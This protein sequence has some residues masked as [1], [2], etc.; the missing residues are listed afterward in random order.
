MGKICKRTIAFFLMLALT[1][2]DFERY[3]FSIEKNNV[4][5]AES[6]CLAAIT[7]AGVKNELKY[8]A[9]L[10]AGETGLVELNEKYFGDDI[11]DFKVTEWVSGNDSIATVS[12]GKITAIKEGKTVIKAKYEYCYYE[13]IPG[14]TET[15]DETEI[16]E[17]T[18]NL[19]ETE[20]S[21][22]EEIENLNEA[23][24]PAETE[25]PGETEAPG[26]KPQYIVRTV[27]DEFVFTLYVTNPAISNKSI[28][29][30]IYSLQKKNGVYKGESCFKLS[31]ISSY[32]NVILPK[33]S[34]ITFL[35]ENKNIYVYPK[36]TG[37]Y[38]FSFI[39]D[40]RKISCKATVK[41]IYFKLNKYS[42]INYDNKTWMDNVTIIGLTKGERTTLIP[43]GFSKKSKLKWS[44]SDKKVVAV[45]QSGAIKARDN[46]N[47]TIK[48]TDGLFTIN[49]RITVTYKK[50]IK[51]LRYAVKNYN[52]T[53]SQKYRM[54]KGYYDC[55][56]Y[57]W[58]SY[59][60]AGM[61]I[62][63]AKGWAPTAAGL[64]YWCKNNGYI[65]YEG[66]VKVSKLKPGD[67]IFW[68]GADNKRYK[69]IYHVDIYQGYN[70]AITVHRQ[71][72]W[73]KTISNVMVARPAKRK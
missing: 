72:I 52:S 62:G 7:I 17:E 41:K 16:P 10:A 6:T 46:G 15:P 57:V 43:K 27:Y 32:S 61:N 51:A 66:T 59:M 71:K 67:L 45:S 33:V 12:D 4:Y 40:G 13:E 49:Y 39:V 58:K 48:V 28:G 34:G 23:E 19:G 56:S 60:A 70:T 22:K 69:G 53:Y 37:T 5:A 26:E 54:N 25:T 31:G 8:G 35:R 21:D 18:E 65:Y 2:G 1:L 14:E 68:K 30:N 64:A 36:K 47:A 50:S 11:F 63:N 20:N 38:S 24:I 73:G 44:T 9:G 3:D 55:S 42:L 29:V